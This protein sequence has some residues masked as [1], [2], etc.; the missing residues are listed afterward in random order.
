ME[1][2]KTKIF[3]L[4][5]SK[6]FR[7]WSMSECAEIRTK[8]AIDIC[9]N[10]NR[11]INFVFEFGGYKLW[12]LPSAPYTDLAEVYM[13]NYYVSYVELIAKIYE[14]GVNLYFASD[15]CVVSRMN[16]I[17]P[18]AMEKYA[19][20]FRDC[21]KNLKAKL[22]NNINVEYVRLAEL[23]EDKSKLEEELELTFK[24]NMKKFESWTQV[25]KDK[26]LKRAEL[27]F[28]K[29]GNL[30]LKDL[31]NIGE[32]DYQQRL[33]EGAVYHDAFED[34]EKRKKFV[35]NEDRILL[36]CTPIP[37]AIAIG[38]TKASVTK[39]WTGFGVEKNGLQ[40]IL[41]PTHLGEE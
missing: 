31:S 12:R 37:E 4:V 6:K 32:S 7:K 9:I 41:S 2:L 21:I 34:C 30:A 22:P 29:C 25:K 28:C 20:S 35:L 11:A 40:L 15:D 38:T 33:I 24:D 23:Y 36:F 13:L 17:V 8:R 18:D 1:E 19:A 26:M 10:E 27:N 39:F 16:N 5:K 3:N 14:P